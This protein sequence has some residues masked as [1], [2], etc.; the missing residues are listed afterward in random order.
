DSSLLIFKTKD[1]LTYNWTIEFNGTAVGNFLVNITF[2]LDNHTAATFQI[3]YVISQAHTTIISEIEQTTHLWNDS[4]DFALVVNNS[5]ANITIDYPLKVELLNQTN[6]KYWFRFAAIALPIDTHDINISFSHDYFE[7]SSILVAFTIIKRPTSLEARDALNNSLLTNETAT[8][9]RQFSTGYADNFSIRISYYDA[10]TGSVLNVT[11]DPIIEKDSS[12]LIFKTKNILTYNWTI[13]FNGTAVGNFLVNITFTLD[14]YTAATFQIHYVIM[15]AHTTIISEIEQ[16][17]H[18]WNDSYD[19]VLVVNNSDYNENITLFSSANITID[20]PLKVELLNQTN[21]KYWFRFAPTALPIDTHDINISFSHDYFENSSI[22]VTFT[23]IKRPTNI[24]GTDKINGTILINGTSTYYRGYSPIHNDNI[25]LWLRYYDFF[26]NQTLNVTAVEIQIN[27]TIDY[28]Y[29]KDSSSLNWTFV[30]NGSAIGRF[31]INFTFNLNNYEI[32]MFSVIYVIQQANTKIQIR[33]LEPIPSLTDVKSGNDYEFWLVWQSEYNEYLNAS[34]GVITNTSNIIMIQTNIITG[35]HTFIFTTSGIGTFTFKLSFVIQ[36]YTQLD[37]I[38]RF[39]VY[40]GTL[41]IDEFLSDPKS[42][43]TINNLQFGEIYY[44]NVFLKDNETSEPINCSVY[45]LP[46]NTAFLGINT[47]G[48]HSFRYDCIQ[49]GH[50]SNLKI[51]FYLENY[52]S[53]DYLISFEVSP[54]KLTV[55]TSLSTLN[56]GSTIDTLQ[57][58]DVYDFVIFLTDNRTGLPVNVSSFGGLPTNITFSGIYTPGNHSFSYNAFAIGSFSFLEIAISLTNYLNCSYIISFVVTHRE[59][60]LNESL[61][62]HNNGS[63]IDTLQY[64]DVYDFV[65]FLTDNRTGLPI[66][67]SSFVGLPT[68]ITFSG[69]I[70]TGNHTFSYDASAVGAFFSLV[71]VFNRPNYDKCMYLFNFIVDKRRLSVDNALSSLANNTTPVQMIIG[72]DFNFTVFLRDNKTGNP[73]N[74]SSSYVEAPDNISLIE[75]SSTGNHLFKYTANQTG[76]SPSLTITFSLPNYYI[77]TYVISFDVQNRIIIINGP[78]SNPDSGH[79]VDWLKYNETFYFNVFLM[80]SETEEPV[81]VSIKSL[82]SSVDFIGIED[83]GN[84][85]FRYIA[86]Q[87]GNY[88]LQIC[89]N[90]SNCNDVAYIIYLTVSPRTTTISSETVV[91]GDTEPFYFTNSH[92]IRINWEDTLFNTGIVDKDPEYSGDWIDFIYFANYFAN[93]SHIFIINGSKLGF[94]QLTIRLSIYG[95]YEANITVMFNI[96]YIPTFQPVI[97]Y[98]SELVIGESLTITSNQWLTLDNENVPICQL[99]IYNGTVPIIM[100]SVFDEFPFNLTIATED[101][102]QGLYNYTIMFTTSYGF[103]NHTLNIQLEIIGRE[104]TITIEVIPEELIQGSDFTVIARLEYE[105]LTIDIVGYGAGVVALESLEN[106]NVSFEIDILYENG[107]TEVLHNVNRTNSAGVAKFIVDGKYTIRAV[108]IQQITVISAAT[109]LGRAGSK[110]TSDDFSMAH[111]FTKQGDQG[112]ET[113]IALALICITTIIV[114]FSFFQGTRKIRNKFK[115]KS[116]LS[117]E[118]PDTDHP[119]KTKIDRTIQVGVP[120]SSTD[121]THA[122]TSNLESLP[123]IDHSQSTDTE[124]REDI[125]TWIT[126]FPPAVSNCEKEIKFL[127]TLVLERKSPYYGKTSLPYLIKYSPNHLSKEKTKLLFNILPTHTSYFTKKRT[128]IAITE[129]GKSISE[130]IIKDR[131][132]FFCQIDNEQ[133]PATESAYRCKKCSRML[134]KR[135]YKNEKSVDIPKCPYCQGTLSLIQ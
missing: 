121:E 125:S 27:E 133:H 61:S 70:T 18:L 64:G 101:L 75:L 94:Y 110:T 119:K 107:S 56:N 28:S 92:I 68:N 117:L 108:G 35:N 65:I 1:I 62:T 31:A 106:V 71:I 124:A 88:Y 81:N 132:S 13:E 126:F 44:F 30:F 131:I 91:L 29:S 59:F 97:S 6:D 53:L 42:N 43:Q 50:F 8:Y 51:T 129:E 74:V 76:T 79:L 63:T 120:S 3:R 33:S 4:Y 22:L 11:T 46:P 96:T 9:Y 55:N 67:V 77:C 115:H 104:I 19:F 78:L 98:Q 128:L 20:Y 34:E 5:D 38:I 37:F 99:E 7:N 12:L 113:M 122:P 17:T 72:N 57:Y 123:I 66:N 23:I 114:L 39:N 36:N 15:Q 45:T 90:R 52:H 73:K 80:D 86:S 87:V 49:A 93:G 130:S 85:S 82:P 58:G 100:P 84:H 24:I 69:I 83:C 118:E 103:Q 134:C 48:N 10:N 60:F 25:S 32:T 2:T 41:F 16:T 111:Q 102:R 14:N 105:S 40:N 135:C 112:L 89:F 127:F 21:D 116:L 95:Y 54:G 47:I 26:S 109:T